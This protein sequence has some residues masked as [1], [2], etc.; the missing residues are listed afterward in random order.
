MKRIFW[1]LGA[2]VFTA[3]INLAG[4]DEFPNGCVSCHVVRDDGADWRLNV[5]MEKVGHG[6]GGERTKLIPTGCNR[7]HATDD[8]GTASSISKL[9]HQV[10]Y[11]APG[12]N[13]YM[14]EFGGDCLDCH[15]IDGVVGKTGIKVGERNW[16]LSIAGS[17]VP[18]AD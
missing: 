7:C 8:S 9:T 11:E 17:E 10:H 18:G 6:R 13:P 12:E 16:T 14:Q 5:L 4:A 3:T 15:S 1:L 2:F